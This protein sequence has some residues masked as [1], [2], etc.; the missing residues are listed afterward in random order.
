MNHIRHN[1]ERA[2]MNHS[3]RLNEASDRE[4]MILAQ[5][6]QKADKDKLYDL[7]NEDL[8]G[9]KT[10]FKRMTLKK[11][12]MGSMANVEKELKK[13]AAAANAIVQLGGDTTGIGRGEIMLAY[14]VENLCI[15]GGS[16]DIDLSLFNQTGKIM[17]QAELKE[18]SKTND[19]FLKGWRTGAKHRPYVEQAKSDLKTLYD[20]LKDIIPELNINTASGKEIA[21]KVARDEG[22]LFLNF[23]RDIDPVEVMTPLQFEI[24]E[25]P[26]GELIIKKIGGGPLGALEDKKTI[27]TIR[28]ILKGQNMVTLKSYKNI[29]A[30]LAKG[31]GSVKEKF[32]FIHTIGDNKKFG[33]I[34]FKDNLSSSPADTKLDAWTGGTVKVKVKA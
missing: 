19:G 3:E 14:I 1:F 33:G 7:I 21:S 27:D 26:T 4:Y 11:F 9:G 6:T 5:S 24:E 30:E 2:M 13:N 17:D 8:F 28:G 12:N 10:P 16:E 22:A 25:V 29:E 23:V 31:F 18:C 32:V 34:Y 20:G 15:G